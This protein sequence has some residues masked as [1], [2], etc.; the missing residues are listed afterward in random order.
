M[1]EEVVSPNETAPMEQPT[2][3]QEEVKT[4]ETQEV[5]QTEDQEKAEKQKQGEEYWQ[6]N[7]DRILAE[8]EAKKEK[9][10]VEKLEKELAELRAAKQEPKTLEDFDGDEE[11]FKA[12]EIESLV[13]KKLAEKEAKSQQEK[14]KQEALE[15]FNKKAEVYREKYEGFK[16]LVEENDDFNVDGRIAEYIQKGKAGFDL[17][18][19]LATN[20]KDANDLIG[21]D[22]LDQELYIKDFLKGFDS[23][24]PKPTTK[25][26]PK[27]DTVQ[28]AKRGNLPPSQMSIKEWI[29]S[30]WKKRGIL[31]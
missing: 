1:T 15:Q 31:K 18:Y 12:S 23:S 30:D 8:R 11:A 13:E 24:E 3:T 21:K 19:H 25:P 22:P 5:P 6:K 2:E 10:R 17:A 26:T 14:V 29:E 27:L 16:E 7:K 9:K 20:P 4:E 28:T